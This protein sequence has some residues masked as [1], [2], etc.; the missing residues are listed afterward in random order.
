MKK[1]LL[2]KDA[3][4]LKRESDKNQGKTRVNGQAFT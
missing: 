1:N 4:R 3:E 2:K